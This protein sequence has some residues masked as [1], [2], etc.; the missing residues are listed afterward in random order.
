MAGLIT[1]LILIPL[2]G[3]LFVSVAR[4]HAARVIAVGF[5]ALSAL[6]AFYLWRQ[7]DVAV[8]GMQ[9]VERRPWIPSIGAEYFVGI[10]G[11]SLLL[12]ILT[13]LVFPFAL[14]TRGLS[15]GACA[16]FLVMQSALYGNFTAQNFVLWFLF[17]EMSLVPGFLLIK[18]WGGE[19][20]DWAAT[21]FFLYTFLGSVAMLLAFLGIYFVK[22][23]F[24][25][26]TLTEMARGGPLL[27]GNLA[28]LAFAGIFLGLAVKV[29][30]FPFHTWLPDAY[31]AAPV[32]VSMVLTGVLSK[33]G[34]YGFIRLL[35]PLFPREIQVLGPWLLG[36]A[37]C[38]IVFASLAAWA[39]S[40]LKR[41]VAYL[42]INHLGYCL[43]ALFA[44]ASTGTRPAVEVQAALSGV[45][46]QI[47]NHGVTAAALFYFVGLLEERRGARGIHDFGGLMQR[48]P[49]LC[50][51]MMVAMFSSLGLPGLNG[52]IGEFLIFKGSFMLASVA[53]SIAVLGLLFTAITFLRAIQQLFSGPLAESCATFP[54]LLRNEKLVVVPVTALMVVLGIAPQFMFNV[55]NST[56]VQMTR[57][58]A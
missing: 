45:F 58:F 19:K 2:A 23:S 43:L 1:V 3:A 39:Q 7:F 30:L 38:S 29:P 36:L 10:D 12:V 44:V 46:M 34:V 26:A 51:W 48:T 16:L 32:G 33:M 17:Y 6:T 15:R 25:F 20:R 55:F 5:C 42:S 31:E 27:P 9:L 8:A 22:G 14:L 11:L 57:L 40:D 21:K 37:V 13:S 54:D 53:T 18:I 52:F 35:L 56:V 41:M 50:G 28:W 49:I 47:F 4:P 24:D